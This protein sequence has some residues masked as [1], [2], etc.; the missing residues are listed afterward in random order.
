MNQGG[1]PVIDKT[2][3]DIISRASALGADLNAKRDELLKRDRELIELATEIESLKSELSQI[4]QEGADA[5][6]AVSDLHEAV[7]EAEQAK[8]KRAKK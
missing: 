7:R 6:L 4:E 2:H 5:G 3:K 1:P 8:A